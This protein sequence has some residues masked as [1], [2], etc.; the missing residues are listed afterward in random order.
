VGDSVPKSDLRNNIVQLIQGQT[1]AAI[2]SLI[3]QALSRDP[4]LSTPDLPQTTHKQM[5]TTISHA[6]RLCGAQRHVFVQ[7]EVNALMREVDPQRLAARWTFTG[8]MSP[9]QKRWVDEKVEQAIKR[10]I[11]Q[12]TAHEQ[13]TATPS[14]TQ[15]RDN[16]ALGR[17]AP[18][19]GSNGV[20]ST[21][22]RG[23]T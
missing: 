5:I 18:H 10:V 23:W 6:H 13:Q 14:R 7:A 22:V 3:E 20:T 1:T 8:K 15:A 19:T 9:H 12:Q 2:P 16:A 4:Q 21:C 17:S 11:R